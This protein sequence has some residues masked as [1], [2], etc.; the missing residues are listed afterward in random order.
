MELV[1]VKLA[2][3]RIPRYQRPEPDDR[4]VRLVADWDI[5]ACGALLASDREGALWLIDGQTRKSAA[6]RHGLTS[7]PAVVCH[8]IDE[9]REAA[10]FLRLNRDR[11][12][13]SA[14]SRHRAEAIAGEVRAIEIDQTLAANGLQIGYSTG[15]QFVTDQSYTPIH[16]VVACEGVYDDGGSELLDR[17]VVIIELAFPSDSARWRGALVRGVGYFLARDTWGA[18]DEKVVKTLSKIESMRL[19]EQAAHWQQAM[20]Q[21]GSSTS[22]LYMAKAIASFVYARSKQ[23]GY[24]WEPG[25]PGETSEP[26]EEKP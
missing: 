25:R 4:V 7:L 3:L 19:E 20:K 10:L 26:P 21:K 8:G 14:I 5:L 18:D 15:L 6:M 16:C 13:V 17:T 22:P 2:R 11:L 1:E 12:R 9:Q 23:R 24:T